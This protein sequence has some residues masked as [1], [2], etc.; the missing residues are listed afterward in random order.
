MIRIQ[1]VRKIYQTEQEPVR[2]LDGVTL[3][4][5]EGEFTAV[6]GPSGCGKTTLLLTV[7]GL[8]RPDEGLV[9]V[10]S[11]RIYELPTERR[12]AF[13]ATTVG[14]VFQQFHL[15]P[16]LSVVDNVLSPTLALPKTDARKRAM[17]LLDRFNMSHRASHTPGEL[18]T[19]ERQRV[20]LA[21][22][23]L[24]EPAVI[25]ADEPTGNLDE[26]NAAAVLGSLADFTENGGTVLLV[27]HDRTVA[28]E[29]E[30]I[31]HLREG[32]LLDDSRASLDGTSKV[33]P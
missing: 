18:S 33:G 12:A 31:L 25:L 29:A 1:D 16:Y 21:R 2:A 4:L 6:Q 26:D 3:E 11:Q 17:D 15:I 19:G 28:S 27:T 32:K 10:D 13:R 24:Q 8:L 22:A 5:Q 14:F 20:A 30:K 7:G 23:M 9:S